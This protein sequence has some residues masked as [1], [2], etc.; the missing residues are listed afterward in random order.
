MDVRDGLVDERGEVH[1]IISG[2]VLLC[3]IVLVHFDGAPILY[4][5]GLAVAIS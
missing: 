2:P 5:K 1:D 3:Y 4:A